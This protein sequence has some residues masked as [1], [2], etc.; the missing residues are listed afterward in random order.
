M[1]YGNCLKMILRYYLQLHPPMLLK[2]QACIM[3]SFV[4]I[5]QNLALHAK[6]EYLYKDFFP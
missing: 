4:K 1:I 3:H 2:T 6:Q 5:T